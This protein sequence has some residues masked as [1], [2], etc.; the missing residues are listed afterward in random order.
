M[1]DEPESFAKTKSVKERLTKIQDAKLHKIKEVMESL[2]SVYA[3]TKSFN[4][5]EHSHDFWS[6]AIIVGG[7]PREFENLK[8]TTGENLH[9]TD[10][11]PLKSF[12]DRDFFSNVINLME[13]IDYASPNDTLEIIDHLW[14]LWTYYK[15]Y[16]S[17]PPTVKDMALDLSLCKLMGAAYLNFNV[18]TQKGVDLPR[19]KKSTAKKRGD[20]EVLKGAVYEIYYH[21]DTKGLKKNTI[22]K[23]IKEKLEIK[24]KKDTLSVKTI[25]RYLEE[26]QKI[27]E[28]IKAGGGSKMD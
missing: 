19:T 8:S 21:L 16:W 28:D 11:F 12:T 1:E 5:F 13:S 25:V 20:K 7:F 2:F 10:L 22:A 4:W 23:I 15:N 24:Y 14:V 18:L 9:F 6:W 3:A 17:Y 27:K 26:N